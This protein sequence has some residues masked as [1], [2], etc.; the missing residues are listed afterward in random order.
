M[1]Q[2]LLWLEHSALADLIRQ[3]L[4]PWIQIVHIVSFSL[5]VGA[6]ALLDL[7]LLGWFKGL[8]I[9]EF[10]RGPIR[11]AHLSFCVVLLS[12]FLLFLTHPSV[13]VLNSAFQLKLLL[14]LVVRANARLV[15]RRIMSA[16]EP[17]LAQS[18]TP[19]KPQSVKISIKVL[20]VGSLLLWLGI[21]A[22]GRMIAYV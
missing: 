22:C 20:A 18:A 8:P 5:T 15:H 14:I 17:R 10:T 2:F 11:L 7:R 16:A 9:L 6:I 12:G 19:K 21:I 3:S 13:L 1:M 4:Y